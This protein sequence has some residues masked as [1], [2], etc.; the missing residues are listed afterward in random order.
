MSLGLLTL[1]RQIIL[2][3]LSNKVGQNLNRFVNSIVSFL[4]YTVVC[5][6]CNKNI[7]K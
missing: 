1:L 6:G 4:K 5:L 2:N 7:K 3:L